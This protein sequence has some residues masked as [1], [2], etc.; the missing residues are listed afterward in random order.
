M[1]QSLMPSEKYSRLLALLRQSGSAALAFSGGVDSSFLLKAMRVSETRVLAVTA[2]SETM[3]VRDRENCTALVREI[4]A[5]HLIIQTDELANESFV[6]NTPERCFFCKDELFK[7]LKEIAAEK[8]L[9]FLF[10]GSNADDSGD[11]RPGR[12]AAALHGVRSPLAECGLSKKE[13]RALSRELGL[14]TWDRPSSPCLSSRIP[15]GR[16]ITPE[17][18]LRVEKAEEFIR[19]LGVNE[20]R[21]R[22]HGDSARIEVGEEDMTTL[23]SPSNRRSIAGRLKSLGFHFVSLDLEGFRSGSMNRVLEDHDCKDPGL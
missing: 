18:L 14:T 16:R 3:P 5:D 4:G 22:D 17:G 12:K 8:G 20:V 2:I 21:V 6:K 15:Y 9:R 10:D 1:E 23:L 7:K 11:Y 19:S 13:I